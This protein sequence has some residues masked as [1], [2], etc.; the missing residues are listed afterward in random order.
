MAAS[1]SL[2]LSDGTSTSRGASVA[3]L[4]RVVM[5]GCYILSKPRMS[6]QSVT[7]ASNAASSTSAMLV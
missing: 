2:S 7:A 5:W 6:S 4:I 3:G 1:V